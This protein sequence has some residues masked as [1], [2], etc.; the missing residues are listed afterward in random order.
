MHLKKLS[1][2]ASIKVSTKG[3]GATLEPSKEDREDKDSLVG[4]GVKVVKV[5]GDLMDKEDKALEG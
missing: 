1:E 4:K 5:L 3:N 2:K